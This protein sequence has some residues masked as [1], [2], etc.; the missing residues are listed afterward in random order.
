[1]VSYMASNGQCF[2]VHWVL[3]R[4]HPKE[5]DPTQNQGLWSS[6][7]LSLAPRGIYISMMGLELPTILDCP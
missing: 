4:A 1:M 3:H 6:S 7:K 5:V 2:M